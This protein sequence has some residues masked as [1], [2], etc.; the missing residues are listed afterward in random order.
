MET[1]S[2]ARKAPPG[3]KS[4]ADPRD[5]RIRVFRGLGDLRPILGNYDAV[6]TSFGL[7]PYEAEKEGA[8]PLLL[9]P[10][11]YHRR[12]SRRE[13]FSSLGLGKINRRKLETAVLRPGSLPRR[14][15]V[16]ASPGSLSGLVRELRPSGTP[17]CPV[18]G[19]GENPAAHRREDAS[20]F[21]CR[22]S[23]G[24]WSTT[25]TIFSGTTAPSTAAPIW[26]TSMPSGK[27]PGGV[28]M[29]SFLC[30][31]GPKDGR[32]WTWAAPRVCGP[33]AGRIGERRPPRPGEA[34]NPRGAG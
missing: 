29:F 3:G 2:A 20:F 6:L 26:R 21:R 8:V 30:W 28:W 15:E 27:S 7:T 12:L 17:L 9:D 23:P 19:E 10:S 32:C 31:A 25:R 34:G 24:R 1:G 18:C 13:G 16:P 33:G 22:R 11:P 4:G 5:E 14:K